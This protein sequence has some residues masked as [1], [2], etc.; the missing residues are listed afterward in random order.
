MTCL[1]EGPGRGQD[2]GGLLLTQGSRA[3]LFAEWECGRG[4]PALL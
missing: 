2:Y 1:L 3:E 4:A